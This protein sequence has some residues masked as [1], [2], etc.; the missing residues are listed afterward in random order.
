MASTGVSDRS[1]KSGQ[2]RLHRR[3]SFSDLAT[4]QARR[5]VQVPGL[6]GQQAVSTHGQSDRSDGYLCKQRGARKVVAY[7]GTVW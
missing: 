5:S 7:L 6:V 2:W 4:P 1:R 3:R